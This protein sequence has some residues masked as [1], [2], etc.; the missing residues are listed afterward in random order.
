MSSM[1]ART[2]VQVVHQ[3]DGIS[4]GLLRQ[5]CLMAQPTGFR[6]VFSPKLPGRRR[7]P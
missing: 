4:R 6:A 5:P 1:F 7:L 2:M 3:V